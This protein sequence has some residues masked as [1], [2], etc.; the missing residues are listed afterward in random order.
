MKRRLRT[1]RALISLFAVLV[2]VFAGLPAQAASAGASGA[3]I[4]FDEEPP[5][6]R[7]GDGIPDDVDQCPDAYGYA[8][9]NGCSPTDTDNDGVSD[10]LDQCPD[11]PGSVTYNGCP[12]PDTDGDGVYDD[13]DQCPTESGSAN[14][15]GCPVPDSDNDGL[16]DEV[17]ACPTQAGPYD[18]CPL[19]DL[20]ND[21]VTDDVDQC[22]D[23]YGATWD[24]CPE[25]VDSDGDGV[26]DDID[27]CPGTLQ[28]ENVDSVGCS[29]TQL[30]SDNDGV[31]DELDQCPGTPSDAVVD[32]AGCSAPVTATAA[33]VRFNDL[34][35]SA[36]DTFVIPS[37]TGVIYSRGGQTVTAGTYQASGDVKVVA[38]AANGY[39]LAGRTS[40]KKKF[41]NRACK[42]SSGKIRVR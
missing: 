21:G 16:N 30:D 2:V 33:A 1:G 29:L 36:N 31:N 42:F 20:D 25:P 26:T 13:T 23:E 6:D 14:Y 3:V 32:S 9:Y 10:D 18:G 5:S 19:T 38:T 4:S 28:G 27:G 15:N 34:C 8:D 41:T 11:T 24:G 35:G 12:V 7:D 22:P 17:D 39:V 37:T 40:W